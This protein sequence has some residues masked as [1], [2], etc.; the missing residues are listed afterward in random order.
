[1]VESQQVGPK[2]R[3][4]DC[5]SS[6]GL[7]TY[8]DMHTHCYS[9][10]KT[11][12]GDGVRAS[13]VP[14][15][16]AAVGLIPLHALEI[17]ELRDR[18][19]WNETCQLFGYGTDAEGRQIATYYDKDRR[20]I[21]QKYRTKDKRFGTLG[22]VNDAD[23]FGAHLWPR[24]GKKITVTEGEIDAMSVSQ[25]NNNKYPVV[26]ISCGA[27]PQVAKYFSMHRA[28][29]AGFDEVVLMFDMD[30]VGQDAA[31]AASKVL[32]LPY[33]RVKI[34]SLPLK[35]ASEMLKAGRGEDLYNA[36][37]RAVP[38]RPTG[39]V[40]IGDI[41]ADIQKG[42]TQGEPWPWPELTRATFGRR[43]GEIYTLG[44][45]TGIGKT[46][47]YLQVGAE[48][49]RSG[50]KVGFILFENSQKDAGLRI[51]SAYAGRPF[52]VPEDSWTPEQLSEALGAL[53]GKC[54]LYDTANADWESCAAMV[55]YWKGAH[56]CNHIVLDHLSAFSAQEEDDRKALDKVM[57]ELAA[58]V[59]ELQINVYLITHLKRPMGQSHEEGGR[60]RLDQFRGSNAIAMW[61]HFCFALERNQQS[62]NKGEQLACTL[63]VLKD[64]N[65][66]RA[67]GDTFHLQY[68]PATA[69]LEEHDGKDGF[70]REDF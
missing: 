15:Q 45:G 23:P 57:A 67:T 4:P 8:D 13:T 38:W 58:L 59:A 5:G 1:M 17:T 10:G 49:I 28:Y 44:A 3:C 9:C 66:G 24:S 70:T 68:N 25:A 65:T 27:G 43:P 53:T 21:G 37:W 16:S 29:F 6:D 54:L 11:T 35:D 22:N 55:R 2:G 47:T 52:F 50:A 32:A 31:I 60:V 19:L 14:V 61:S 33:G 26:S 62:G 40:D 41:A 46:S 56:D 51:A 48:V 20:A 39:Y 42:P 69:R 30:Q 12:Q 18:K 63:R 34:A 64:R 36:V 7:G